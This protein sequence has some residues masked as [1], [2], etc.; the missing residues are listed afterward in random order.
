MQLSFSLERVDRGPVV[1]RLG[2]GLLIAAWLLLPLS[3]ASAQVPPDQTADMILDSARRAYNEKNYPFAVTRF[4]EFLAKFGNHKDVPSARYGL[5][6]SLLESP[7]R[8][9]NGALE[10][11]QALLGNKDFPDYAF[12]LYH[13]AAAKRGQGVKELAEAVA[14]PQEAPQR[15]NNANQRFDEAAQ[16]FAA[17]VTAFTAKAKEPAA[18]A[19]ELPIELEWAARARCDQAEMQ[20]RTLKIKEALATVAPMLKEP[21]TRSR[22]HG[23]GLY[24]HGFASFLL[25][26]SLAAGRSLNQLAPFSDPIFGTHARY[27]LARVHHQGGERTEAAGHYQGVLADY[28]RNKAA[29]VEALKQ[30]DK[31]K[32]D[33][34]EKLRLEAL[35]KDPPPDHVARSTFYLGVLMYEDGRFAEALTHF[36]TFV[37]QYPTSSLAADAQLRQGFSQVQLKQFDAAIK[38]LQP[39]VDKEPRLSDQALFWIAKAQAGAGDLNNPQAYEQAMKGAIDTLRR[40]AD[41]AGQLAANDPEAKTRRA[42][43]LLE[44]GDT[45]QLAKL[46]KDAAATYNQVLNEKTLPQRDEELL[47]RQAAALHLAADYV[48]SDKVCQRFQQTFPKSALLPAVLFRY[49]ENAYF[50]ALAAEKNPNLPNRQQELLRLNDE[51]IKR[52]LVLVEKYP[53]FVYV[54]L[55]RYG[56]ALGHYRKGDLDKARE[57]LETIPPADRTGDLAVVPYLLADCLIR[58]APAKADDALVAGKLEEQLKAAVDLLEGF[59]AVQP[60]SPEVPDALLKLGL[61]HQRLASLL[62]QPPE[63]AKVL[64]NARSAYERLMQ[65]FPNHPLQPQAVL[66][67]AK[68]LAQAGDPN[69]A[70]NDLRRFTG[71]PL[72][73]APVAPMALVQLATLLRAQNKAAEAADILDKG[74]QAHEANL[75]KDPAR[76]NWVALL[77]YHQGVALKEAG[78]RPEAR[79]LLDQVVKQAAGRPEAIEAALRWGQCLKEEGLQKVESAGK[80][81]ATPNLKPEEL[82]AANQEKEAG[83]KDLRDTVAFLEGQAEQLRQKNQAPEARARMLYDAA[84]A[85]R[86]LAESEVAAVRQKMQQEQ[87][88]KLKDE[89]AKKTPPGRTPPLVPPPEIALSA[90]PLQPA[91]QKA[92]TLYQ[93]LMAVSPDLP[94]SAG[95]ARLELAEL[96]AQRGEHDAAVKLLREALDKE[97]PPELTEKLRLRLGACLADKGDPKSGL[98]QFQAVLQN[99]KSPLLPHAHYRAGEAQMQLSEYAEAVKHLSLFR[100]KPEFQNLPGLTD[101]ALFRLGQAYGYLGQWDPSRQAHEQVAARFG[102][103]PWVH[104][105]RYGVGWAW[106][107]QKQFDNAVNAYAQVTAG[108][109]AEIA[110]RAQLQ[111]GVCRLEQKRYP[112]AATALLVVPFT[113]DY[114]EL[115]A[116]ALVEAARTFSEMKQQDQAAKLLQRVIKDHPESQWAKVAKDRL[117][118]LKGG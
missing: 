96:H 108:T 29:A 75:Q 110:A 22:Y 47:Q 4:R 18:D 27:L 34:D 118:A 46:F 101:R 65:Q 48:E 93:A 83:L 98:T 60:N 8:D 81:L 70:V 19:K 49:A 102:N 59:A 89:A 11:L 91:E 14:K 78:K 67:R 116:V 52:Y 115:S 104:E 72:K 114:P 77:Q 87:W 105:A 35:V 54:N 82:A 92:R 39:L 45:Q 33:P 43:M 37:Q 9:Y 53:E 31:F 30:P 51:A 1:A 90:V 103:S 94:L 80:R 76:A 100:D 84:W 56:V 41:R 99:A 5:A 88:Q 111:T 74:R 69:G 40:A 61:C 32:N 107:N 15:K 17:A 112:E 25:N 97:P 62:A 10:Q 85:S 7:E 44:L 79:A 57:V 73:N 71:D 36:G 58:M 28:T 63:K 68:C 16:Q 117:D 20:L 26:D 86:T 64:A 95:D 13:F 24:L 21:F 3:S 113:Y 38:T 50:V 55:A 23:Q 2:F 66:E 106:Q 6:L 109:T 42:E 12:V